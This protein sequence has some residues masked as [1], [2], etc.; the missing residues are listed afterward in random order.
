MPPCVQMSTW[1]GPIIPVVT[2]FAVV[3]CHN[4]S[5]AAG[6]NPRRPRLHELS[7][8]A[9]GHLQFLDLHVGT[10]FRHLWSH[11]RWNPL[12]LVNSWRQYSWRSRRN[13]VTRFSLTHA[14]GR[15]WMMMMM[16]RCC[17]PAGE[18]AGRRQR[19]ERRG[20]IQSQWRRVSFTAL[21]RRANWCDTTRQ[22]TGQ[23]VNWSRRVHRLGHG[24][25]W[26]TQVRFR[27]GIMLPACPLWWVK[28]FSFS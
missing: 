27:P 20:A 19:V 10:Y 5:S 8:T 1:T 14:C 13:Y 6:S 18:G 16:I 2:L 23:R 9:H 28:L 24:L 15:P 3:S 17:C 12:I 26:R 21:H 22:L 4:P 11:R 25:R 7:D